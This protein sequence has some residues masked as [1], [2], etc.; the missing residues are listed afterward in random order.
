[1]TLSSVSPGELAAAAPG[2]PQWFQLY[3]S[4]DRGFTK[5]LVESAA[6]AGHRALVL[7]VDFPVAGRRERDARVADV[8]DA[9][10]L[11]DAADRVASGYS[12]GM[13][14]RLELAQALVARAVHRG[15][16]IVWEYGFGFGSGSPPS[17]G[18]ACASIHARRSW[19]SCGVKPGSS[20]KEPTCGSA[21]LPRMIVID[22]LVPGAPRSAR[23][24]SHTDISRVGV[25][26]IARM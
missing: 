20:L 26:L 1:S 17:P 7:T 11:R 16:G 19:L 5:A 6:E 24:P 22:T 14:R 10:D 8:L 12:G 3:W 15:R 13:I 9:M 21:A 2:A 23:T 25:S 4:T 18:G